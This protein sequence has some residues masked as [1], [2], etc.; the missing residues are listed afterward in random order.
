MGKIFSF[1]FWNLLELLIILRV[2]SNDELLACP[3]GLGRQG[4]GLCEKI[5]ICKYQK[6]SHKIKRVRKKA[7]LNELWL[8]SSEMSLMIT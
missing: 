4:G 8:G 6:K 3:L 2:K 7:N 5:K 1:Q